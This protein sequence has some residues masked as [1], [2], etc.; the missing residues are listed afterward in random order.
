MPQFLEKKLEQRYGK[1]NPTVYKIMNKLGYMHGS[2][3]TAKGRAAQ[4]KHEHDYGKG[5]A[6][7]ALHHRYPDV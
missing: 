6:H 5:K 7:T 2:K 4:R 1:G 3:E